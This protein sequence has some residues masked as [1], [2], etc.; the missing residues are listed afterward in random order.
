[1]VLTGIMAAATEQAKGLGSASKWPGQQET[2]PVNSKT[3]T[4]ASL[5]QTDFTPKSKLHVLQLQVHVA[6][7]AQQKM[8]KRLHARA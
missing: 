1:M 8:H 5:S 4:T 7:Q 3:P 6:Q 2:F